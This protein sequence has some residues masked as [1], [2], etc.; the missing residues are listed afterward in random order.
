[1]IITSKNFN[2]DWSEYYKAVAGRPP[3]Q[4]IITALNH[5]E[6]EEPLETRYRFAVDLG[7]GEGRDT[8]FLLKHGWYVLAIDDQPKAFEYLLS[9]PDLE[10]HYLLETRVARFEETSWPETDLINA[11]NSL[12]F[13]SP[14][15]FP[16]L[17]KQIVHSIRQNGRFAGQFFGERETLA[18]YTTLTHHTDKQVKK[19]FQNFKIEY[20]EETEQD[21]QTPFGYKHCH[22]FH[23]VA[24]KR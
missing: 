19:L 21:K 11:S 23:V 22:M 16:K 1:L 3:R 7:C 8:V 15:S 5:F 9:R 14:E 6:A 10:G 20:F 12:P 4:T 24:Q 2:P 13:C 17:W 18:K